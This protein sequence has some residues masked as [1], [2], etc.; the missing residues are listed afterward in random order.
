MIS[1]AFWSILRAT[2]GRGGEGCAAA[3]RAGA[4]PGRLAAFSRAARPRGRAVRR[5]IVTGRGTTFGAEG[6]ESC[7]AKVEEVPLGL[8]AF[9]VAM[10]DGA[11]LGLNAFGFVLDGA[12]LGF[13]EF[14]PVADGA[15]PSIGV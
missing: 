11:A 3:C 7:G 15:E 13:T 1:R 9:G 14:G 4:G 5:G 2:W 12:A 10:A 6:L 8:R